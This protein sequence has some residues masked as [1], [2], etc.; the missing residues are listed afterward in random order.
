MKELALTNNALTP[1]KIDLIKRQI[2]VG[3]TNDE[4]QMFIGIC[5]KTGLDPFTKQIYCIKRG[6]KMATQISIDGQRLIAERSGDYAGQVGPFWCGA[7]GVW[8][9]VWLSNAPPVAAKVG[10]LRAGFRE[11][12]FAVARFAA[13]AQ[14]SP[15]WVK[16]ADLMIAKVAEALALRKAFPME[17]SGLYTAEEMEQAG[18]GE[19]LAAKTS[20]QLE[21]L[22]APQPAAPVVVEAAPTPAPVLKP[23]P[24][25]AKP[26]ARPDGSKKAPPVKDAEIVPPT[27]TPV[28]T[29][30]PAP[31]AE[32]PPA[33]PLGQ[34]VIPFGTQKGKKLD[35]LEDKELRD[36]IKNIQ[37]QPGDWTGPRGKDFVATL[38]EYAGDFD[39]I[40]ATELDEP[41]GEIPPPVPAAEDPAAFFEEPNNFDEA[42]T[43]Q[44]F[45]AMAVNR[46]EA[47]KS[48]DELRQA[49]TDLNS[50]ARDPAKINLAAMD[51]A[52]A[53][54]FNTKAKAVRDRC[55][56]K[57]PGK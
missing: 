24:V 52:K 3:A 16:M 49:W 30:K 4:L 41:P 7:D 10:V 47:A 39:N 5:D 8:K 57:F 2:A 35:A 15:F 37:T 1:E 19:D 42:S 33:M 50:D 40:D 11:P 25:V 13:Y 20:A 32:A 26:K 22:K 56:L 44:S 23:E 43:P 17:L 14:Q 18:G 21:S 55:K 12:L 9:D 34:T 54:E 45:M 31:L 48:M 27:P 46:L 51:P 29:P 38:K 28:I 36:L 53:N 6:G